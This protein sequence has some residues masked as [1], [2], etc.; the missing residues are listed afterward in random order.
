MLLNLLVYFYITCENKLVVILVAQDLCSSIIFYNYFTFC[1][2][3]SFTRYLRDSSLVWVAW[4]FWAKPLV[5]IRQIKG[6]SLVCILIWVFRRN[7]LTYIFLRTL[8]FYD[9]LS[10][11]I[12][13]WFVRLSKLEYFLW[14]ILQ[15]NSFSFITEHEKVLESINIKRQISVR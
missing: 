12:I 2:E 7:L 6:F 3:T 13:L 11:W 9:L 10:S 14:K 15:S 1:F 4:W 5:R 8:H